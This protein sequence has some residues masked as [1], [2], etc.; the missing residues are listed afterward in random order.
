MEIGVQ[1]A[2]R[3]RMARSLGLG[4]AGGEMRLAGVVAATLDH[5]IATVHF[6]QTDTLHCELF[7]GEALAKAGL[8]AIVLI[9]GGP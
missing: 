4:A 7:P 2:S 6:G 9:N 5:P 1:T 8:N 3:A